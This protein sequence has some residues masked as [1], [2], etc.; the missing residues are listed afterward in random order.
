M[1]LK[2]KYSLAEIA[3]K[4]NCKILGDSQTMFEYV[5]SIFN[6][7][8]NSISYISDIKNLLHMDKTK[9]S[10]VITTS[11]IASKIKIPVIID[12]N[13]QLLFIKIY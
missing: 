8:S 11:E 12:E 5:S 13:P 7:K 6:S 4:Y 10:C 9:L 1:K 3:S 2:K